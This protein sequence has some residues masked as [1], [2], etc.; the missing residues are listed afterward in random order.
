MAIAAVYMP[1]GMMAGFVGNKVYFCEPYYPHAWPE[2]YTLTVESK[3]VGLGVFGSTLVVC[4]QGRPFL[5]SGIHPS[6][7]S[8]EKQALLEPCVSKKS[9]AQDQYGVLYASPNGLV[10]IGPGS[11][12]VISKPLYSRDDWQALSPATMIAQIYAGNYIAT[13]GEDGKAIVLSRGDTPALTEILWESRNLYV[14]RETAKMYG[15]SNL[16]G[17]LYQFDADPNNNL[18]Y[19]WRSQRFVVFAPTAFTCWQLD[20]DYSNIADTAS[21]IASNEAINAANA[22]LF[23]A[24]NLGG[25]LNATVLNKYAIN[26]SSLGTPN[27]DVASRS[28]SVLFLAD[29]VQV[30][31]ASVSSLEPL[32]LPPIR[33]YTWEISISGTAAARSFYMATSVAELRMG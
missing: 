20:A 8:Q 18:T 6:S 22:A 26:A 10:S 25:D 14:D 32:R 28:V 17:K 4:T 1:N 13:Y 27:P 7:M 24:G 3:I 16:D 30:Y 2:V 23:A 21:V 29:G 33:A 9:I 31:S 5:I 15:V 12:D 11:L 19:E